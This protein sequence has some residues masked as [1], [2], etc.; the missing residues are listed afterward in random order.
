MTKIEVVTRLNAIADEAN[1]HDNG[2]HYEVVARDWANYGKNR[3][4]FS[5]VETRDNSKHYVKK[6]Y[7][8]YDNNADEYVAGKANIE[9]DF[10][11]NHKIEIVEETEAEAE[12][13]TET[14]EITENEEEIIMKKFTVETAIIENGTVVG[15][16]ADAIRDYVEAID[17]EEA[18]DFARD[19][20]RDCII[21]N[22]GD[23]DDEEITLRAREVINDECGDFGEWIY[24]SQEG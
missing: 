7:G 12:A 20:L 23:P 17:A 1:S 3:T 18:M 9:Y 8:F 19:Y 22:G 15:W 6:D 10:G 2:Y 13:E 14:I 24:E 4:Y 5:I 21:S 11:G 16:D